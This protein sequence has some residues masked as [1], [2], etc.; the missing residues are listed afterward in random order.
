[1]EQI[2]QAAHEIIGQMIDL[3]EKLSQEDFTR[4]LPVLLEHSI[5]K[6]YRHIIEFFEI[7]IYG[8]EAGE[9]NYDSRKHDPVLENSR[10]R[11]LNR[12]RRI[13]R[14]INIE[15][16]SNL[17]FSGSYKAAPDI[18]FSLPTSIERELVYN[19]EHAVHHMAI[20]RIA[21]QHEFPEVQVDE[22]FGFAHS[23]LKHI[24]K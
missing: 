7:L 9:I 22:A 15:P 18:K 20:I 3:A 12:L 17:E 24:H 10:E 8:A 5:G 14:G 21:L 4:S 2:K 1:M 6:H 13:S 11:C 16:T 19:I 23:T